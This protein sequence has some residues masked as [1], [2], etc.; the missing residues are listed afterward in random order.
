M[1][2]NTLSFLEELNLIIIEIGLM[3][4]KTKYLDVKNDLIC[5]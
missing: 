2:S 3:K 4:N 1:I 5:I